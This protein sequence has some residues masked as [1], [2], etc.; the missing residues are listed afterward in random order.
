[1]EALCAMGVP[2]LAQGGLGGGFSLAGDYTIAPLQLT[3]RE[4]L[5]LMLALS[6]V[7]KMS[8]S[9]FS[10]ERVSLE[11]KLSALVPK[12]HQERVAS[13]LG[14]VEI[15][16]PLRRK[17]PLL[18]RVTELA[19]EGGWVSLLIDTPDG[20]RESHM[21]AEK[22]YA[23]RGFWYLSGPAEGGRT[24]VRID[25]IL[26]VEPS[27]KIGE[28]PLPY[29][30]PTHPQIRV[31]LSERGARAAERDPHLGPHI[32]GAG[33]LEFRCPPSELDWYARYFGSMAEDAVIESPP[34]LIQKVKAIAAK[35]NELYR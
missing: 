25:R 21:R 14:A 32:E 19:S 34:E 15:D 29:G 16:V 27:G 31:R 26:S 3:W 1:M 7:S 18:D 35:L 17:A 30:H 20:R 11:A 23:D 4:T 8:D 6:S 2:I 10:S 33:R 9:P 5:L 24:I 28:E 12:K 22:V 13:Y